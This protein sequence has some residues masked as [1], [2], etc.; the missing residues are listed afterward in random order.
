M[1]WGRIP[2]FFF[3]LVGG[4]TKKRKFVLLRKRTL[5]LYMYKI[6][7]FNFF[8]SLTTFFLNYYCKRLCLS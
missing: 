6:Y 5:N 4:I 1:K 7:L 2:P 3:K 8:R